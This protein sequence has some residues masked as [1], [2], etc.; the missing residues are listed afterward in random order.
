M[1]VIGF[2][3]LIAAVIVGAAAVSAN[4]GIANTLPNGF[5]VFGHYFTGSTGMLFIGG[6][7]VGAVGMLGLSLTFGGSWRSARGHAAA[8]RELRNTRR[9]QQRP[10]ARPGAVAPS[11]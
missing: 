10:A 6:I 8:R 11:E 2:I 9:Q 1:I 3:L 7:V 5:G 4:I